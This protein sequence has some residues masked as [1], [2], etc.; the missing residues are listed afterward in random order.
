[1]SS[2]INYKAIEELHADHKMRSQD[3]R[4]YNA[5][6]H[7]VVDRALRR[8]HHYFEQRVWA[9]ISMQKAGLILDFGCG[10]G[11]RTRKFVQ[12]GWQLY[13]IDIS[14]ESIRIAREDSQNQFS[15]GFIN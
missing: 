14:E 1:M 4:N 13:G 9:C 15:H 12:D 11:T 10:N 6:L 7:S 3:V 5:N 8:S 2:S